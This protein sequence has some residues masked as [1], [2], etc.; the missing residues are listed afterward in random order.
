MPTVKNVICQTSK[1]C[2]PIPIWNL[3]IF[4]EFQIIFS[5][6]FT[7]FGLSC[8]KNKPMDH[9]VKSQYLKVELYATV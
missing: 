4:V 6:L 1:T 8:S 7:L 5:R 9:C 2:F 3:L